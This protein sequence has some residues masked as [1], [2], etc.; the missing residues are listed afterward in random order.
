MGEERVF[1]FSGLRV[2]MDLL[3]DQLEFLY[4]LREGDC[5]K[6]CYEDFEVGC[7]DGLIE[8]CER[9]RDLSKDA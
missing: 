9:M 2:D 5:A 4:G 6:K 8:M 7:L 1:E 3:D